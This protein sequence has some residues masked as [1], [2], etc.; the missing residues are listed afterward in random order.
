MTLA[1]DEHHDIAW[2]SSEELDFL[3]PP[4]SEAV[5]WYCRK[6]IEEIS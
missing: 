5:K 1:E 3:T 2:R 6:A 4:I